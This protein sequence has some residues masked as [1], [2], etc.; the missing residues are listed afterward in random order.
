MKADLCIDSAFNTDLPGLKK[1]GESCG[2]SRSEICGL[3]DEGLECNAPFDACGQCVKSLIEPTKSCYDKCLEEGKGGRQCAA[4][5]ANG[6]GEGLILP[7]YHELTYCNRGQDDGESYC[8]EKTGNEFTFCHKLFGIAS[9]PMSG[10]KEEDCYGICIP[11]NVSCNSDSECRSIGSLHSGKV[12]SF[13]K[14]G[15][16]AY[17]MGIIIS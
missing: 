6:D 14:N 12:S 5:C 10:Q 7:P 9:C 13:C 11:Q 16:C 17:D 15:I 3:C 8:K 1:L 4:E 2:S